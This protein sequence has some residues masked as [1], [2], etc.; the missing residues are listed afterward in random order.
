VRLHIGIDDTDSSK[1]GCTTYVA[2]LLVEKLSAM[3]VRFTD[4]PNIVRLNPNI[5]Y[6]TRGNAAVALRLQAA[7]SKYEAV[8]EIAIRTVE[9]NS[10]IGEPAT[11]P[12]IVFLRGKPSHAIAKLSRKALTDIVS[13]PE[14]VR[15]LRVAKGAAVSYG[16]RMGLV[17]ALAAVGHTLE[18]DHTYELIA[19]RYRRNRGKPRLVDEDSVI[20]MDRL[21]HP[22]TFNNYDHENK[23][24]LIT[25]HGPDPVLLGLRGETPEAVRAAFLLLRVHEPIERWAIFRTNHGTDA[26]FHGAASLQPLR[27]NRPVGLRG[28]VYERPHRIRGGHVFLKLLTSRRIVQCAAFEPT[29]KFKEVVAKFIPG[30]EV[31]AF[32][33]VRRHETHNGPALTLNLEKIIVDHLADDIIT[34]NPICPRCRK[35]TKSAG[36]GQGFRCS[37]CKLA[38]PNA[39]KQSLPRPRTVRLGLYLPDRKAHRHL[40][41]PLDRY[42]LE[43][44]RWDGKPPVGAWH[45]P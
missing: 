41:K 13:I 18:E 14:A 12:A 28:V 17:G 31:T 25:P 39:S 36:R 8:R 38:L 4:Y 10:E 45:E 30:D 27:V 40:T 35:R 3:R 34:M 5:P 29:G 22:N 1:G 44:K 11:D 7:D 15:A 6:K 42:G 21:T 2:A 32:G 20:G 16:S 37:V 23:R 19:Y 9:E 26:H 24:V 43:K 33:G